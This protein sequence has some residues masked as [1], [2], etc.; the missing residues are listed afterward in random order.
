MSTEQWHEIERLYHAA[1]ERAPEERRSYLEVACGGDEA[2]LREVESLLANDDLAANFLE[3][4]P[5]HSAS[6][7][8]FSGVQELAPN[9]QLSHYRILDRLGAGGMGVVYKATDTTLGRTVALK[10]LRADMLEDAGTCARFE[11]EARTLASLTHSGIATIYGLEEH[12][13]VRFLALEYVPG[14]TLAERL[15][16][17]ALPLR[18][19]IL[20]SK[21]IAE[22]LE[23]AHAQVIIHRDLKPSNIKVSDKGQV[24]V[25]DFGLAKP[26]ERPHTALSTDST[27]TVNETVT[28]SMTIV[29]TP[30][31][32]SPEQRK[33]A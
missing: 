12:E 7:P 11:R 15:R 10:L 28:G 20:I 17:G 1:S 30:A 18:E 25:L 9:S 6:G 32:M 33:D 13:G 31:Y 8:R 3:T 23:T 5:N 27:V 16:R 26:M 2:L 19:A 22:A 29:A 24:K 21:Q 4:G 14:P